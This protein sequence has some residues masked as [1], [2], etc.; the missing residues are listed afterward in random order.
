MTT[1][2][3]PTVV[4][5]GRP[6]VGKSTLFNRLCQKRRSMM[7]EIPETTR[8]W[9]DGTVY[10]GKRSFQLIDTGGYMPDT[11]GIRGAV[12]KQLDSW[13][14]KAH[15]VLWV[16][17]GLEGITSMEQSL[18][19]WL[20]RTN[21]HVTIVVNKIDDK[22]KDTQ[23]SDFYQLGFKD[24]I[25]ISAGH[26]RNIHTLLDHLVESLWDRETPEPADGEPD[27]PKV[28]AQITIVGRPNVGKS[29]LFNRLIGL[30]RSIV[31]DIPGTTRDT[32]DTR[33]NWDG[34]V[35]LIKDT[36][37]FR[38]KAPKV[39]GLESLSRIMAH[40]ALNESDVAL[41][42]LDAKEGLLDGDVAVARDIHEENRACVVAVNKW[43]LVKNPSETIQ[44]FESNFQVV[45]PF[46]TWAP[47]LFISALTGQHMTEL[48]SSL[49]NA[50]TQHQ[51]RFHQEDLENFFWNELQNRPYSL[52]GKKMEFRGVRQ[53]R[54]APVIIH[55]A[56]TLSE[57]PHFSYQ[58]H[59]E[60]MFRKKFQAFGA[61]ILFQYKH[62]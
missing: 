38:K 5:L 42:L 2:D 53:V 49:W 54:S 9:I 1:S 20:R 55:L 45:M 26:G 22:K 36:A 52:H 30:D 23:I 47:M 44:N 15:H 62:P 59:L 50:Q 19:R 56:S 61:P 35:F 24:V 7:S 33:L 58:R 16:V 46:L 57:P 31:S 3:R 8:D 39:Q 21:S 13:I 27:R 60:N 41:L 34:K 32:I 43:D 10:W 4:L 12:R 37:G 6:N 51:R 11:D 18:S 25:P 17:D 40:K 48:L 29:S 14:P 28:D